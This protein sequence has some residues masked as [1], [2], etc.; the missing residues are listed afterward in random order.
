MKRTRLDQKFFGSTRGRIVTLLRGGPATVE[1]LAG[2]LHLTDNAVRAH[3]TTLERD[4]LIEQKG[5]RPSVRKP[6][7]EYALT[8]EAEHLFPK[9]HDALLNQLLEVLKA[10]LPA[11]ELRSVLREV[12]RSLAQAQDTPGR[13]EDLEGRVRQAMKILEDLGG[14]P[15]LEID[16]KN[17]VIRSSSCPLSVAV[18]QHP[19]VCQVA[20]ALV[21]FITG[22]R[23]KEHCARGETLKCQFELASR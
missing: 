11:D 15:R 3:L 1:E 2:K 19:E 22:R 20:E 16:G 14:A 6:H 7:F 4:R 9:A 8:P 10:H 12:G 23:V 13:A 17:F 18:A 5:M 21:G